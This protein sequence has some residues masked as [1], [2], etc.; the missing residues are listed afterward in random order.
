MHRTN[1]L[2]SSRV[3]HRTYRWVRQFHLWLG[4]WGALAAIVYGFTGLVMNHRI[5]ENPWPQGDSTESGRTALQVPMEARQ[6]PEALSLWLRG[7]QDLDATSIRKGPPGG[8]RGKPRE[9]GAPVKWNLSG[10]TA[11]APWSLE[12]SPGDAT[13]EVKHTRNSL[14][15]AFNRLHKGV[16]GGAIWI[17]LADSFALGMLFLGISGIWMWTR[18]RSVKQMVVSVLGVS[19]AVLVIVLGA[20]LSG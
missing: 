14:L 16:G 3:G 10:G 17:L 4:A 8:G 19:V 11:A 9:S 7:T 2:P 13:A 12:Y 5:G 1:S 18:G 15:A 20:A 6:T